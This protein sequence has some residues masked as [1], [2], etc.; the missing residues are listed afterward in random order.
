MVELH[1][2]FSTFWKFKSDGRAWEELPLLLGCHRLTLVAIYGQL[3][4]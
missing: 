1:A 3:R 4:G 2:D